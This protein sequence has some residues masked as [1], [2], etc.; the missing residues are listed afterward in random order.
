MSVFILLIL[1]WEQRVNYSMDLE[2]DTLNDILKGYEEITYKNNSPYVLKELYLH[3]YTN[4]YKDFNTHAFRSFFKDYLIS[5]ITIIGKIFYKGA[6]TE[7]D[8]V[9]IKNKKVNFKVDET[10]LIVPLENAL[11]P[12]DSVKIY[13]YFKTKLPSLIRYRSGYSKNHYDFGQFY[14]LMCV[15]DEKGWHNRKWHFNAEFYHNFSNY[16]VKIKVPGNFLVGGVGECTSKNDTAKEEGL[17]EVIFKAENVIDYF[18]SCDPDFMYKD[19]I[20]DNT[21]IIAFYRKKNRSYKDSFLIRGVRA[22]NYLKETLGEYPYKWLKIV[23][24]LIGGGMEY[25]GLAL[26]GED[27]FDLILHEVGHTYFMGIL[28]S[29]QEDEAWLDEGGTTFITD[30]YKYKKEK[31]LKIFY[32]NA[33]QVTDLIREGFDDILLTPSY[34]FKNNYFSVYSKGSH[35]YAML[36]DIMG[37]ENFEKFLKEYYKRFRFKHPDTDSLFKVSEEIYGKSLTGLKNVY[38]K[39]LPLTDYEITKFKKY[40]EENKWINEIKIKNNGNTIYPLSLFLLKGKDTFKTRIDFFKRDTLIKLQTDFETEKVIIDPYNFSLDI[41]RINNFYPVNFEKNLSLK[42]KPN[43]NAFNLN[44]FPFLFYSPFSYTSPGFNFTFSYLKKYPYFNGEIFYSTKIKTVYYN[45]K[46][47]ISF[48]FVFPQNEIYLNALGFEGNYLLKIG[49]LKIFQEY[50]FDPKKGIFLFEFV[51]KNSRKE[52]KFFD[53]ANYAGLNFGFNIFP[54]TDLF[55]NELKSFISIYPPIFSGDYNFK[56]FFLKYEFSF[57]PFYR[58]SFLRNI[59]ELLNIKIFY[60]RIQGNFPY[61]EHFNNYSISSYEILSSPFERIS[62]LSSDYTFTDEEGIYLKG[63]KFVRFKDVFSI[64]L[65]SGFKNFGIFY[66]KIL[67]GNYNLWDSGIYL[68][69]YFKNF[70]LKIYLPFY[71]NNPEINS[72]SNN[73]DFRIKVVL[74]FSE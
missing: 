69:R 23:D 72:E 43:E 30:Y 16:N 38:V 64:F 65:S 11:N 24:G 19:T 73:F 61:Q 70:F 31:K 47:S 2:L 15:F 35:I 12:S 63:Y 10:I 36:F 46:Y 18:F 5:F 74:K 33:V 67:W 22:Y 68:K 3:L 9:K 58:F 54:V 6:Y 59:S 28:A 37:K 7:I 25:P 32:D 41:K 39:G 26:C 62:L 50:L 27:S 4:A 34:N 45:L 14:P 48:P 60:G 44:Y 56:K 57:L 49:F 40:K 51:Y 13:I 42:H 8:S 17:K 21:H 52:S 20:I 66:E 29:N 1:L 55:Y 71:T 53:D